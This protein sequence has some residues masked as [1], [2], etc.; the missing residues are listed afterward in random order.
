MP[1]SHVALDMASDQSTGNFV[2]FYALTQAVPHPAFAHVHHRHGGIPLAGLGAVTFTNYS[3][4]T[5]LSNDHVTT[6]NSLHVRKVV[7]YLHGWVLAVKAFWVGS[8]A[9]FKAASPA[10][11][12]RKLFELMSTL[13]EMWRLYVRNRDDAVFDNHQVT[14]VETTVHVG[15]KRLA[16]I[17]QVNDRESPL[18][19]NMA[20]VRRFINAKE[21]HH[22]QGQRQQCK[23][24]LGRKTP[25][26]I[27]KHAAGLVEL[28]YIA[29]Q[30]YEPVDGKCC[31]QIVAMVNQIQSAMVGGDNF[32][33]ANSSETFN[34][35]FQGQS[36]FGRIL[37][38][39]DERLL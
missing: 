36:I 9:R 12:K 28:A 5:Y 39:Y 30:E 16:Q 31:E 29:L 7:E 8:P 19:A 15:V 25:S 14:R 32:G 26:A 1:G 37:H 24:K 20:E 23:W 34:P 2:E 11:T 3:V 21:A 10:K 22:Q 33:R 17:C 6:D 18:P 4:G 35:Q 13:K 27:I 38:H